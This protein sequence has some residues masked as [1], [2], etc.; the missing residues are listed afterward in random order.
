M[1]SP[2]EPGPGAAQPTESAKDS[3][4]YPHFV[5]FVRYEQLAKMPCGWWTQQVAKL[6]VSRIVQSKKYVVLDAKFHLI[7]ETALPA[8]KG[9]YGG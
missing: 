1:P 7:G 4:H 6:L 3:G 8:D 5:Q 9:A 2:R